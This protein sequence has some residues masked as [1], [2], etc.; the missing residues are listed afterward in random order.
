MS[1]I[2]LPSRGQCIQITVNS[3]HCQCQWFFPPESPLLG[4]NICG[5]CGH[6]I[7][8]H[9]DYVSTVVNRCP[10]NQCAAYVQKTTLTQLCTCGAPFFEH[11]ATDNTKYYLREPWTVSDYFSANSNVSSTS[12]NYAYDA[13]SSFDPNT[14]SLPSTDYNPTISFGD[15]RSLPFTTPEPIYSPY[16]SN[17]SSAIQPDTTL[18]PGGYSPDG[19]FTHYSNHLVN[20]PYDRQPEGGT[21]NGSFEY[22]D[23]GNLMYAET[24]GAWSGPYGA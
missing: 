10:A 8:A 4:Q 18:T 17:T 14:S 3:Q 9:A 6:G 15:A 19:Y 21:T 23:Y 11:I 12:D 13:S 2:V 16:A 24:P 20:S 5:L 1:S 22:Q 7:H